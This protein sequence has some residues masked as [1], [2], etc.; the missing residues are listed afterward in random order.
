M[1]V[2]RE[3]GVTLKCLRIDIGLEYLSSQ[4]TEYFK[5]K[6]IKRHK[7]SPRNPQQNGIAERMN[8]T[9]IESKVHAAQLWCR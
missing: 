6:G 9:I 1:L 3:K 2:E 4:F 5:M 8:R 7:T